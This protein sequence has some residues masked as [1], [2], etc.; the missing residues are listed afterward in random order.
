MLNSLVKL[1]S[2][3]QGASLQNQ[4]GFSSFIASEAHNVNTGRGKWTEVPY[5]TDISRQCSSEAARC[6]LASVSKCLVLTDICCLRLLSQLRGYL[7]Y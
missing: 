1:Y 4:C 6:T 3:C 2:K 5:R 7:A